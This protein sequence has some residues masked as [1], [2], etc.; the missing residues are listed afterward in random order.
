MREGRSH[1]LLVGFGARDQF[2]DLRP[3]TMLLYPGADGHL[4]DRSV[5]IVHIR[6]CDLVAMP[7]RNPAQRRHAS[8]KRKLRS[9]YRV[10]L[11]RPCQRA[12]IGW[13]ACNQL[14]RQLMEPR[15]LGRGDPRQPP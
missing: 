13:A 9:L 15:L 10:V 1:E 8:V 11:S 3:H 2:L 6:T 12:W 5:S 7:Q 4:H 14:N